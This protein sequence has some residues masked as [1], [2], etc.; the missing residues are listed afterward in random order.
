MTAPE[1]SSGKSRWCRAINKTRFVCLVEKLLSTRE[2]YQL[3]K[4]RLGSRRCLDTR[5][6]MPLPGMALS[7]YSNRMRCKSRY[8]ESRARFRIWTMA[9]R[10]LLGLLGAGAQYGV[11]L[12]FS[13][14]HE[15]E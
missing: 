10:Q 5:S 2:S 6:R 8:L 13:R 12:P 9:P 15:L 4:M 11:L 1:A 7:A 14:Q 3:L